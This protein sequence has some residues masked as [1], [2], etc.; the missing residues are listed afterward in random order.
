MAAKKLAPKARKLA[1]PNVDVEEASPTVANGDH[2][3][4]ARGPADRD[5]NVAQL[6]SHRATLASRGRSTSRPSARK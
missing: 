6:R 4:D 3:T 1:N 2:A 5:G